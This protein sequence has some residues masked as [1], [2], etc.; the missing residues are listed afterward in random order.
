MQSPHQ[1]QKKRPASP[2]QLL[3]RLRKGRYQTPRNQRQAV[4]GSLSTLNCHNV[5]SRWSAAPST[6]T[7]SLPSVGHLAH[8]IDLGEIIQFHFT[9]SCL[10]TLPA[11]TSVLP[12]VRKLWTRQSPAV[13]NGTPYPLYEF[14]VN[15]QITSN[16]IALHSDSVLRLH[17]YLLPISDDGL[18]CRQ[19]SREPLRAPTS[20]EVWVD[21]G[22][23][24]PAAASREQAG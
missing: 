6:C 3:G 18:R 1:S 7:V 2:G 4:S 11:A 5:F 9:F 20:E 13:V 14:P 17:V 8:K 22:R 23:R 24:A 16:M 19:R 12:E 15:L 10:G 21:G